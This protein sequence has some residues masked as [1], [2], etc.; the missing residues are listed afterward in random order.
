MKNE[1]KKLVLSS[2]FLGLAGVLCIWQIKLFSFYALDFSLAVLLLAR[3]FVGVRNSFLLPYYIQC[4]LSW[5]Q[6]PSVPGYLILMFIAFN[7]VW[8]DFLF[9]KNKYSIIGVILSILS[10]TIMAEITNIFVI[11]PLYFGWTNFFHQNINTIMVI[12]G[13][14]IGFNLVKLPIVFILAFVLWGQLKK[15]I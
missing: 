13:T 2:L 9:N 14:N 15:V 5:V 12:V 8:I 10:L 1:I 4:F 6:A 3:R 7:L 11:F